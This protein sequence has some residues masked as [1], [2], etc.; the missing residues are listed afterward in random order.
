MKEQTIF[1]ERMVSGL[2]KE[3]RRITS[4]IFTNPA[5]RIALTGYPVVG[6]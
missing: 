4:F 5:I 2:P 3:G 6:Q 1:R